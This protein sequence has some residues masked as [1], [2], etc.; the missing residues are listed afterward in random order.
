MAKTISLTL[1]HD[2]S[3]DEIRRRLSVAIAD[4]REKYPA[5]L[6]G[7]TETWDGN[8][9]SFVAKAM[10]QTVT[11]MVAIRATDVHVSI[12]LPFIMGMFAGKVKE[13][14]GRE[15]KLLLE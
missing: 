15:G 9:M 12:T 7:A 4:A 14:I 5:Q 10:G 13:Q 6:S 8:Q 3:P 1:P 11:G 2:K